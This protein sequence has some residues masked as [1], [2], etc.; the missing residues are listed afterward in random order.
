MNKN[1]TKFEL[2]HKMGMFIII[3]WIY[4]IIMTM[5]FHTWIK[6]NMNNKIRISKNINI[7]S[8]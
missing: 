5:N 3:V 1:K 6:I 4:E 8:S 7:L 2:F